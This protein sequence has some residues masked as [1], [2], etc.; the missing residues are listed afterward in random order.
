MST[1]SDISFGTLMI[2]KDD[3]VKT[4]WK[5]QMQTLLASGKYRCSNNL[6]IKLKGISS[7][8]LYFT[9]NVDVFAKYFTSKLQVV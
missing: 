6:G 2:L 9:N 1:L 4:D 7:E 8:T 3:F 5:K